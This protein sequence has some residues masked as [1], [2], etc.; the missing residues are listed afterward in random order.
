M[1][2]SVKASFH[3]RAALKVGCVLIPSIR[4]QTEAIMLLGAEMF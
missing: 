1:H 4:K 2:R 3:V